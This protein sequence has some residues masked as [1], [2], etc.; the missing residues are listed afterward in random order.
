MGNSALTC[1]GLNYLKVHESFRDHD[2]IKRYFLL[3]K[4]GREK[5]RIEGLSPARRASEARAEREIDGEALLLRG[6]EI[7]IETAIIGN[8]T[9][10]IRKEEAQLQLLRYGACCPS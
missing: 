10:G 5:N 8:V 7:L 3:E 6:R 1:T 2:A 9:K 4:R